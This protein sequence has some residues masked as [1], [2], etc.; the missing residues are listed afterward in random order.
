MDIASINNQILFKKVH[1]IIYLH[2]RK[3]FAPN[4]TDLVYVNLNYFYVHFLTR[5][6]N[7]RIPAFCKT[8]AENE[9]S[10]LEVMCQLFLQKQLKIFIRILHGYHNSKHMYSYYI[11]HLICANTKLLDTFKIH[12]TIK[13]WLDIYK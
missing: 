5:S 8:I 10:L 7:V 13:F 1:C 6:M 2:K 3:M 12:M 11:L 9:R 4:Y